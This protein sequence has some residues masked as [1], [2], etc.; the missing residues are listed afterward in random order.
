MGTHDATGFSAGCLEPLGAG[1]PRLEKRVLHIFLDGASLFSG[2][3]HFFYFPC[4]NWK[5]SVWRI[6]TS[7]EKKRDNFA[8]LSKDGFVKF[9]CEKN[10]AVFDAKTY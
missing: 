8:P 2:G 5:A 1:L 4:R 10:E 7:G 6:V 9:M 3:C